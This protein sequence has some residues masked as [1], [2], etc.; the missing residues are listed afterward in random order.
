MWAPAPGRNSW[1][2]TSDLGLRV[3]VGLDGQDIGPAPWAWIQMR[4]GQR[5]TWGSEVAYGGLAVGI[6]DIKC[7]LLNLV[8]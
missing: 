6:T 2:R 3:G 5:F 8:N 7:S 4:K 1:C